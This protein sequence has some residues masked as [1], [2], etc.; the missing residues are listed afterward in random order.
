M[1]IR[2]WDREEKRFLTSKEV[3]KRTDKNI[4]KD[5]FFGITLDFGFEMVRSTGYYD[6]IKFDELSIEDREAWIKSGRE[7]ADWVGHELYVGDIIRNGNDVLFIVIYDHGT[8][9]YLQ[10]RV[11]MEIEQ[12]PMRHN[13]KTLIGNIYENY[14]IINSATV[15]K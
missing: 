12:M 11:N 1:N 4:I 14:D 13:N 2:L 9:S 3:E 8:A 7:E 10:K 5:S 6:Q 15:Q